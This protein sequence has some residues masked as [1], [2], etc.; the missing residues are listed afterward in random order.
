MAWILFGLYKRY[1]STL[2]QF[3]SCGLCR[4]QGFWQVIQVKVKEIIRQNERTD[5]NNN[6]TYQTSHQSHVRFTCEPFLT[7]SQTLGDQQYEIKLI[8]PKYMNR[9]QILH[10]TYH[11]HRN[12]LALTCSIKKSRGATMKSSHNQKSKRRK[13]WKREN[14]RRCRRENR[15]SERKMMLDD[16]NEME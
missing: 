6:I 12:E 15:E 9:S 11:R 14:Q 13:G 8:M 10:N 2:S 5:P 4:P 7:K 16:L 3:W 1:A